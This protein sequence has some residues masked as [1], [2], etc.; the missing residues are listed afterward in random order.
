MAAII[1][2]TGLREVARALKEIDVGTLTELKHDLE[3]AG[4]VVRDEASDLFTQRMLAR[5]RSP[6]SAAS[7]TRTAQGFQ[8]RVRVLS[9]SG[10]LLSV[11][12][13]LRKKTGRRAQYGALQVR[14]GLYPGRERKLGE[15]VT[16]VEEGAVKLLRQ[17]G[18]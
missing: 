13:R 2:Y 9:Q 5:P 18:F 3:L 11:E 10:A 15:V 12:Q 8:T 7:I 4:N 16:I 17:H 14:Y 1:R 6:A